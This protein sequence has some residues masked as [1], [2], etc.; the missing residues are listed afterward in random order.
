MPLPNIVHDLQSLSTPQK[1]ET[2]AWFFKTGKGE[3]GEGDIFIGCTV[4]EMR[5]VAKKFKEISLVELGKLLKNKIHEYRFTALEI[6]VMKYEA[7]N[8]RDKKKIVRF[9][10]KNKKSINN[11]DLV[12]TSAPYIIGDWLVAN[13]KESSLLYRLA[14]SK[15][16]WDRRIA[17]V[18]TYAFIRTDRFDH[19]LK[20]AVILM[21]DNHDLIHKAVGW[22]LREVGKRSETTLIDFLDQNWQ[23]MP[24]TMLRYAVERLGS[25][26]IKYFPKKKRKV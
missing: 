19:T 11:W 15:S 23:K 13:E 12:D 10:L 8:D 3:Y 7:A 25:K 9:Y 5:K 17:I 14:I 24:R 18:S 2:S 20:I 21:N 26:R 6:L 4:P 16:L 1:A 22:M